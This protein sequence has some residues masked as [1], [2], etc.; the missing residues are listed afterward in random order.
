M[1]LSPRWVAVLVALVKPG[2]VDDLAI[3]DPVQW[4]D[5]CNKIIRRTRYISLNLPQLNAII[6][7]GDE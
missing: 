2:E 5:P 4:N 7:D 3:F 6:R 1:T